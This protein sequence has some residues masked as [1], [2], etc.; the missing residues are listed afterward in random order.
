MFYRALSF[1]VIISTAFSGN[2]MSSGVL[3]YFDDGTV[4]IGREHRGAT[5][6]WSEFGGARDPGETKPQTALREFTEETGHYTF[7]QVTLQVLQNADQHNHY[8]NHFKGYRMYFLHIHGNKPT[9][10][11]IKD[12]AARANQALGA[13]IAHVEKTDWMYVKVTDLLALINATP[14]NKGIIPPGRS[15]AFYDFFVGNIRGAQNFIHNCQHVAA[16]QP[17]PH[18]VPQPQPVAPQAF[19][20]GF[21]A[22]NYL[23][24]NSDLAN[25]AANMNMAQK[26]VFA[27]QHYIDNGANE[28]RLFLNCPAGFDSMRY[29]TLNADLANAATTMTFAQKIVFAQQ[30]YV[31]HG[32]NEGRVYLVTSRPFNPIT[33]LN[34]H[35]DL[36]AG[37]AGMSDAAKALWAQNHY[38]NHGRGEKRIY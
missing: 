14:N 6:L 9:V 24:Q 11:T 16:P 18:V 3:P 5:Q 29:L 12:N 7:P 22:F 30:H 33:Y 32:T 36:A 38:F 15:N 34:N 37:T 25:A 19:P 1:V 8:V 35:P 2:L 10:Q 4:L 27:R 31:N 21:N 28:G 17:Q 13:H 26:I 23:N 20:A